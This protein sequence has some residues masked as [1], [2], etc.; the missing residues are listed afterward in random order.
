MKPPAAEHDTL[1]RQLQALH[2]ASPLLLAVFDPQDRLRYANPAFRA[3]FHA[4]ADGHTTWL[5]M[6]RRNCAH[7]RGN[8][9]SSADPES[10]LTSAASRRGKLPFRAFEADLGDGRWLWMSETT[11][12]DGWMYCSASD[13]TALQADNRSLR[14]ERDRATRAANTDML[15]GLGNRSHV[16]QQLEAQLARQQQSPGQASLAAVL[17]DLDHFKQINDR[18]GHDAGDHVLRDFARQLQLATRRRDT[19]GRMGGEEFMLLLVDTPTAESIALV[20][21]LLQ[22][23]RGSRPLP[24]H[25]DLRYSASAGLVM[26]RPGDD[27]RSLYRRADQALYQAKAQG[28]DR[29]IAVDAGQPDQPVDHRGS[30][31]PI[32]RTTACE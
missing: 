2:D 28:R 22:A 13:I 15:T 11:L 32:N 10:W 19:C 24:E 23:V 25:G 1:L 8:V 20:E 26:A 17:L 16:R 21:R 7:G 12:P 30:S 5:E 27:P 31:C 3:A 18:L 29:C 9:V 14:Q 4:E 6:M